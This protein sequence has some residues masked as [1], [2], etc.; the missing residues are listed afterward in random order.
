MKIRFSALTL[1]L[2][3]V[4][5]KKAEKY[6][7]IPSSDSKVADAG[8]SS[9]IASTLAKDPQFSWLAVMREN[10]PAEFAKVEDE[11]RMTIDRG[12]DLNASKLAMASLVKPFMDAHRIAARAAPDADL[13]AYLR[14]NT[15]VAEALLK[16]DPKACTDVFKGVLDPATT[17]PDT[18][19]KQM[20]DA[21]AQLLLTAR[22]AEKSPTT[23]GDITLTPK[24]IQT[25]YQ[26]MQSIGAG[27]DTFALLN[28]PARK[29]TATP[30]EKCR[31]RVQMM[32]GA[33]ALPE[34]LATKIMLNVLK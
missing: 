13:V 12:A 5:C 1:M 22:A 10:Y 20:S 26:G 28:D 14:K 34:P 27:P 21:T 33:L 23:R 11:L 15:A 24:D 32:K 3:L 31:V 29:A 7:E 16:S 18:T 19:W 2:L 8:T 25:W 9:S 17:L 30:S 6:P 4:A